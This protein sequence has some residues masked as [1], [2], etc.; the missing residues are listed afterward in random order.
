MT[1]DNMKTCS[2]CSTIYPSTPEFF[3]KHKINSD[4]EQVYKGKCK[5]CCIYREYNP[6]QQCKYSKKY[7]YKN[8]EKVCKRTM[9][10]YIKKRHGIAMVS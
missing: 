7:Y 9:M 3:Y 6:I 10:N 8:T 2:K 5:K 1:T 4:G